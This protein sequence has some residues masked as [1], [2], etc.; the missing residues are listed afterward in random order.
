MQTNNQKIA[1]Y[2]LVL[3]AKFGE[4]GTPEREKHEKEAYV[5]YMGQVISEARKAEK[6]TQAELA[7]RVG[8]NK[9]Y[10]SRIE[11][12]LIEPGISTFNKIIE[13]LGLRMEIVKPVM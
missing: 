3:D 4:I 12:G 5:F 10:I 2:D 7:E 8:M 11:K 9:T 1:D 13:A 6:L